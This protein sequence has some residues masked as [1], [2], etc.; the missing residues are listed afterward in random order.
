MRTSIFRA[1]SGF[2][3]AVA[4]GAT[5]WGAL[6]SSATAAPATAALVAAAPAI[7]APA[8]NPLGKLTANQ[9]AT[10]AFADFKSA[11]SFH[12]S[13]SAKEQGQT[14]SF[15]LWVT[16]KGCTGSMSVSSKGGFVIVLIGTTVWIQPDDKFWETSGVPADQLSLVH[17][18]WLETTG[19]GNN[20]LYPVFRVFCS[21]KLIVSGKLPRLIKGKT[22]KISGHPALQLR[23]KSG[24]ESIY[25]SISAKPE[26]LR[27]SYYGALNFSAYNAR[28]TLTPPPASDVITNPGTGGNA[29]SLLR[30]VAG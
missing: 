21:Q 25:V 19:T 26:I 20:S 18:M 6:A 5:A 12:Y 2:L 27:I 7:T 9:I 1:I 10:K 15:A 14:F 29:R 24:L 8:S 11:S 17:G 13:G 28:V 4:I 30:A 23:T 3:A 22:I 16:G